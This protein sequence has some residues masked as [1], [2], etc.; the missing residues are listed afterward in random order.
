MLDGSG[1]HATITD[2]VNPCQAPGAF[3]AKSVLEFP[4]YR[5][6]TWLD[7]PAANGVIAPLEVGAPRLGANVTGAVWSPVGLDDG[8]PAPLLVVQSGSFFAPDLDPQESHFSGFR[9]VVDFVA[10][11]QGSGTDRCPVPTVLTCGTAEENLAN[12]QPM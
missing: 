8:E 1:N 7:A 3:G 10:T 9:A 11:V 5:T 12:N 6:P 4:G 2:P